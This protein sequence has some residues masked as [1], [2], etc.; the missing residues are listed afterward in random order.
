MNRTGPSWKTYGTCGPFF[1]VV[2]KM[3]QNR[4]QSKHTWSSGPAIMVTVP[5]IELSFIFLRLSMPLF[6]PFGFIFRG[7]SLRIFN[8]LVKRS[9]IPFF[10]LYHP[11]S[12]FLTVVLRCFLLC[13]M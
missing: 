1:Q 12:M 13:I 9:V 11:N 5:V 10:A 3:N 6:N 8:V 4:L 2:H 7:F